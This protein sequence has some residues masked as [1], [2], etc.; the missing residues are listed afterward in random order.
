MA[1]DVDR[2]FPGDTELL[3]DPGDPLAHGLLLR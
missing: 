3:M 1:A 2:S